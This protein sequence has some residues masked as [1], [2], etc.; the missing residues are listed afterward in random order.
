MSGADGMAGGQ[1]GDG[2]FNSERPARVPVLAV[3]ILGI[4]Q[5]V[6][7]GTMYY[8]FSIL[9]P[10]MGKSFGWPLNWVFGA[11]SIALLAGGFASPFVGRW[12]DRFGAGKVMMAGSAISALSLV[13]AAL[14]PNGIAFLAGLTAIELAANFV[15]YGAAFA[16]LVRIEPR[17]GQLSITYLTLMAG[18]A[19][20]IFWPITTTLHEHFGW[21]EVYLIFAAMNL[22]ICMPLHGSLIWADRTQARRADE[23]AADAPVP[24]IGSLPPARRRAGL[25]LMVLGLSLQSMI[26]ASILVHMVPLLSGVGLGKTAALVSTLFGP[27][28]VAS[29]FTN[30]ILGRNLSAERLAVLSSSFMTVAV[31]I[32]MALAPNLIAAI[33]F[34]IVYGFGSGLFSIAS[35]TLP[36]TLFGSEGY[37]TLQGKVL[38]A[39][40][41]ASALAPFAF[42]VLIETFG[43]AGALLVVSL[44]GIG[45]IACYLAVH[46]LG[47]HAPAQALH[48]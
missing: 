33:I 38:S 41:I 15:Q 6:G 47:N 45:A 40:L 28:Q 1:A 30:M 19:S 4:T 18:F 20:T 46:R 11:L 31:M 32:L 9:A 21:R 16:L 3:L 27:A 24:V 2:S 26:T 43:H 10:D 39:R 35:G 34:A 36:L 29:R 37:G 12:L 5:I 48:P 13:A 22:L 25:I 7:Y 44:M 42:L 23:D 17:A 8:S 14:A